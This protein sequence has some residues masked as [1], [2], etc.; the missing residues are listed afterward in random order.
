MPRLTFLLGEMI[1]QLESPIHRVRLKYPVSIVCVIYVWDRQK[2]WMVT[3]RAIS[4]LSNFYSEA[5]VFKSQKNIVLHIAAISVC[6]LGCD[7]P[8]SIA[9]ELTHSQGGFIFSPLWQNM[10]M[11]VT[12]L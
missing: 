11:D 1:P 12:R 10:T 3:V 8:K 6:I 9:A 4:I 7:V 5:Q 2:K